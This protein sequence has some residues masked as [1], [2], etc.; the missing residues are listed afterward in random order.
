M[1]NL[2][3]NLF[4]GLFGL[5]IVA[6]FIF[7]IFAKITGKTMKEAWNDIESFVMENKPIK[8]KGEIKQKW[9]TKQ[10]KI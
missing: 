4:D 7:W 5:T 1:A 3:N 8:I 9:N 10:T 2:I 6:I